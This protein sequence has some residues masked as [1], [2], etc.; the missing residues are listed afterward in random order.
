MITKERV[1]KSFK[2][3]EVDYQLFFE[4]YLENGG[5][6]RDI[7]TFA[8][9]LN[10]SIN[11]NADLVSLYHNLLLKFNINIVF[12]KDKTAIEHVY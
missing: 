10:S 7:N 2:S 6:V 5:K 8:L 1:I 9:F 4:H 11:P 12:N 3:G